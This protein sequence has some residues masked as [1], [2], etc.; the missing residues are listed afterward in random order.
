M[1]TSLLS[2]IFILTLASITK[3]QDKPLYQWLSIDPADIKGKKE[4][5]EYSVTLKWQNLDPLTETTFNCNGVTGRFI[6]GIDSSFSKWMDVRIEELT[7]IKQEVSGG[8][9]LPDFNNLKYQIYNTEFLKEDFY[10]MISPDQRDL[11]KWLVSDA[12]QMQG[13]AFW[14]FDTL[15]F[16]IKYQPQ[17]LEDYK[18]EFEE[19][20]TFSSRYQQLLWS[21]ITFYNNEICAIVKFESWYNPVEIDNPGIKLKGRSLY[22]GEMWI[23]L[24]D[25]Q[26]E[27]AI[28]F[29]DVV[30][31]I[32]SP[33]FTAQQ[34][35]DLQ[36][37]IVFEKQY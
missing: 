30:F 27:Y 15:R 31:R 26:V 19:W 37:E 33:A 8:I 36:R 25:K 14:V 23:S 10:S 7:D 12:M 32:D 17:M 34:L 24:S 11:A 4:I 35:I 5:M 22:W 2:L 9:L 18:I 16:I 6:T 29:E 28:M 20:I 3:S 1:K 13:L 21:G